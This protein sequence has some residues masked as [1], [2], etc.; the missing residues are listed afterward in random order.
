MNIEILL[1]Q[2]S[3]EKRKLSGMQ[4]EFERLT[5]TLQREQKKQQKFFAE[6]DRLC[7]TYD[8]KVLPEM[9]NNHGMLRKL[10][11]RLI[12]LSTRKSLSQWHREELEEWIHELL[13]QIGQYDH[14]DAKA[15]A[16][17][18]MDLQRHHFGTPTHIPDD[19]DEFDPFVEDEPRETSESQPAEKTGDDDTQQDFFGFD[20]IPEP[21]RAASEEDE[22]A[23]NPFADA[24]LEP[25]PEL[26]DKWFKRLF[27][28][29][30]Q[31]LHPDREQDPVRQQEKKQL[32]STLLQA[33]DDNDMLTLLELYQQ[34]VDNDRLQ[35]PESALE[36]LC[37]SIEDKLEQLEMEKLGYL[38][39]SPQRLRV[40]H[41]LY[42]GTRKKQQKNLEQLLKDIRQLGRELPE[43]AR[44]LRNL[45]SLKQELE[46]RR[47]V[48]FELMLEQ[49]GVFF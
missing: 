14:Q 35:V 2:P 31:A 13:E 37:D 29:A 15:A 34:H 26:D 19:E 16:Q 49:G 22:Y 41:L 38:Y 12:D 5:K 48:R 42:A 30:A 23:E 21:E 25:E 33:R 28:R 32:M 46:W 3:N 39:A 43:I 44:S 36:A 40:H 11:S 24:M 47:E 6:I 27:R 18:Y 20:D 9:K 4:L 7:R 8:E 45:T 17:M 10:L 1:D